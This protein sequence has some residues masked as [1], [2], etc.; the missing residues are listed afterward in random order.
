MYE[1][2]IKRLLDII[3]SLAATIILAIPI[4]VYKRQSIDKLRK[5]AYTI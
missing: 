2:Y 4:D 3:L 1:R 5:K